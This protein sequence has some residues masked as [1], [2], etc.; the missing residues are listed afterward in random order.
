MMTV[1]IFA[2]TS[3]CELRGDALHRA[4][5]LGIGVEQVAGDQD[6][7]DLLRDRQVDRR[8]EGGE[9]PLALCGR[10]LAHVGV[11]RAEMDVGGVE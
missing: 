2:S 6:D 10:L 1:R 7:V 9:L 5:R 4:A 8:A 11:T 3:R